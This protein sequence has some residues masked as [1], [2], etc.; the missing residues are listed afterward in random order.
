MPIRLLTP[1][2]AINRR[3]PEDG[4]GGIQAIDPKTGDK[5]WEYKMA[6]VVDA[7]VLS[8]ASDLLFSGGREGYAMALDARTGA[9]LWKANVG[10]SIA[11]GPMT[12]SLAGRQY[13]AF[14]AGSSL[15]VCTLR[16]NRAR[17]NASHSSTRACKG[18]NDNR[19]SRRLVGARA[20]HQHQCGQHSKGAVV[21]QR[22]LVIGSKFARMKAS[23]VT[24]S[25]R[26]C[27]SSSL[28]I[29]ANTRTD[30]PGVRRSAA[31]PLGRPGSPE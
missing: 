27:R 24:D 3:R 5:K 7:G 4:Y 12:Y 23:T 26:H 8:T 10:G 16:Q 20:R 9:L 25:A 21:P 28:S 30:V 19:P 13:I 22:Y 31:V 15:F 17:M 29:K 6:D 11:N 14:A 18:L 1:G 2:P